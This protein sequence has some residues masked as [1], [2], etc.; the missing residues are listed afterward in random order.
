MPRAAGLA[1]SVLGDRMIGAG[2]R[3]ESIFGIVALS[4][5]AIGCFL[6][7]RPFA[8]SIMWAVILTFSTWP[9]Y[10]WLER[11]LGG[12]KS[13]A[14]LIMTLLLATA[15]ILPLVML[16]TSIAG[17]LRPVFDAVKDLFAGGPPLPPAWVAEIPLLGGELHDLWTGI[18]TDSGSLVELINPYLAAVR[19]VVLASG[20]TIGRGLI[21]V[22][23]SV[24]VSFF[25]YRDGVYAAEQLHTLGQRVAGD[26]AQHLLKVAG[27]TIIGVVYGAIGTALAQSL[28]AAFGF[29]I[30]GLPQALLLGIAVFFMSLIP[31]GPPLIWVPV[32][33]WLLY[34]GEYGSGVFILIWGTFVV[35]GIDNLLKPYLISRGTSLPLLLVFLGVI[36]G[37]LA[38]GFLGIFLGPTLLAVGFALLREWGVRDKPTPPVD[39]T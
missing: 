37:V 4:F 34:Q 24:V 30:V 17:D 5:L 29:W 33:I 12:R 19:D 32:V 1:V 38:F 23:L 21:E 36:G 27:D 6:V 39:L 25:L 2:R 10:A 13:L 15:F 35:S 14:A 31:S 22:S 9:V 7:L 16:G 8:S 20:L 3:L 11:T 18:A 26:R 28:L